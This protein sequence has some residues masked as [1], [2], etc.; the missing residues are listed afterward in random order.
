MTLQ[1][2]GKEK[3]NMMKFGLLTSICEGMTFEEVV[4]FA[5][6]NQLECLEVA[7]WPQGGAQR[8]YAGVSHIDVANLDEK[9]AAE[10]KQLCQ[11]KGRR[12]FFPRILSQHTG[13]G[14]EKKK[15]LYQPFIQTDGRICIARCQYDYNIYRT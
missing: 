7:C 12:D 5:A 6:E 14:R 1:S 2:N 4:N 3:T 8:R 9:K 10:I 13:A 15:Q 11:E